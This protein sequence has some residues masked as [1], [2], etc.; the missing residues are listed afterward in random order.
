MNIT[1]IGAGKVGSSLGRAWLRN[2]HNVTYGVRDPGATKVA[3][4][5]AAQGDRASAVAVADCATTADVVVV[6]TP[7]HMT[8]EAL[9]QAGGLSGK[10]VMDATNP[11]NRSEAGIELALGFETSGGEIVQSWIPG[12]RVVKAFNTTGFGNM[13]KAPFPDGRPVMFY[14]GDNADAKQ[15]CHSLIDEIGFEAVDAGG[16][17]I[18][19]LLE[20]YG[21]LWINMAT[22]QGMGVDFAYGLIRRPPK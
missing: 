6:A 18:S 16:I 7:W 17:G 11:L 9:K 5:L 15:V 22:K 1:I 19:R 4:L 3:E 2:G 12:A 20:P 8:E 10:I 14:C 21:M 13:D